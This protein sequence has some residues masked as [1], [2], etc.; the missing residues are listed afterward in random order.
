MQTRLAYNV[1]GLYFVI[2]SWHPIGQQSFIDFF[3]HSRLL[4][5]GLKTL[6]IVRQL[7]RKVT[8]AAPPAVSEALAESQSSFFMG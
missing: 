6:Q 8:N 1:S 5:I 7:Q 2:V 3:C 4:P